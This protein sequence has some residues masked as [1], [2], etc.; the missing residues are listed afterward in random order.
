MTQSRRRIIFF[1]V[2]VLLL[3]A[4]AIL[5]ARATDERKGDFA[6]TPASVPHSYQEEKSDE[7]VLQGMTCIIALVGFQLPLAEKSCGAAIELRPDEPLGYKYRGFTYLLQHRF[8][9]AEMDFRDAVRLDARDAGSQAGY[10]QSLS[11]QGRFH[12]AVQRFGIALARSPLDASILSA[13]GWA[14]AGEGKDLDGALKDCELAL[15]LKPH[16]PLALDSRA[17]VHL[18]AGRN[19]AALEDY[20]ASLIWRSNSATALFGRGIAE[21]RLG[22]MA[23][24]RSDLSM[25]RRIDPDVD[26]T[27]IMVG[28]LEAGCRDGLGACSLP[29]D[30]QAGPQKRSRALSVSF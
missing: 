21:F 30:L 15:K 12:D 2:V 13:R 29:N 27:Y 22:R 17:L 23:E 4:G 18:R 20:S 28:I 1:V 5:Q 25:A 11:G 14:R 16:S 3:A 8:E 10:G 19:R 26:D 9:R 7:A 24:A 6:P